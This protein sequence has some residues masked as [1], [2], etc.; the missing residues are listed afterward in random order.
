MMGHLGYSL[1]RK[2]IKQARVSPRRHE[3]TK[4]A[5]VRF[6]RHLNGRREDENFLPLRVFV[7]SW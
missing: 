2:K 1:H 7:S 6:G 3:D 5:L 4:Q